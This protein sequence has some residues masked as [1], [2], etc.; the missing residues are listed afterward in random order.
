MI[1]LFIFYHNYNKRTMLFMNEK[2][3]IKIS[4]YVKYLSL[5]AIQK[6]NSGHPGL[7]L[8]CAR[9]GVMLYSYFIRGSA[10]NPTY[11]NRDRFILSAGHGSMLLYALNY[12]F[13]YKIFLSDIVN[14]RQLGSISAGHPEYEIDKGLETTTGPLGQG[15]ANAVGVAMESKMLASRFNNQK[16]SLF[17]YHVYTLLG[18]GCMMEGVSNEASSLA[19]HLGLDNLI[20]IYDSN[21]I[22]IDGNTSITFTENVKDRYI[23][24]GWLVKEA[25]SSDLQDIFNKLNE[26][27]VATGKPKLLILQTVIGEGLDKMAGTHKIHGSPAGVEEIAFFLK[28]SSIK[29]I[30]AQKNIKNITQFVE[31]QLQDGRFFSLQEILNSNKRI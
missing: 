1:N 20:A 25:N 14:F 23:A 10:N 17:D 7:P 11:V 2:L 15:I 19:G 26:L 24:Q 27:K 30:L 31:I 13:G 29:E 21:Q 6:A 16:I 18:D 28:N 8:G 22:S 12:I 9:L 3:L 5:M 4:D